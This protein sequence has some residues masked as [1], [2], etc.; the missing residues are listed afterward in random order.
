MHVHFQ[1]SSS[2][3]LKL[4]FLICAVDATL[5]ST[6]RITPFDGLTPTLI[7]NGLEYR[8]SSEFD[9]ERL[10]VQTKAIIGVDAVYVT[11]WSSGHHSA[12]RKETL[13]KWLKEN[14]IKSLW[15]N[16]FNGDHIE[17]RDL[18][19]LYPRSSQKISMK[20]IKRLLGV[21][22]LSLIVKHLFISWHMLQNG[23]ANVL[24]LEDDAKITQNIN[25]IKTRI[26][27]IS[28]ID[29]DIVD[30]PGECS[31]GRDKLVDTH[32]D[33]QIFEATDHM[34]RCSHGYFLRKTGA[35]KLLHHAF[36]HLRGN[37]QFSRAG[38]VT[39]NIYVPFDNLVTST[40]EIKLYYFLNP[41][42][43]TAQLHDS[44]SHMTSSGH[45]FKTLHSCDV[46]KSNPIESKR[47]VFVNGHHNIWFEK[48]AYSLFVD[49]P[50]DVVT[51]Y[52]D[53]VTHTTPNDVMLIGYHGPMSGNMDKFQ[54][55]KLYYNGEFNTNDDKFSGI[56]EE[57]SYYI[58]PTKNEDQKHIQVYY[59]AFAMF[60]AVRT[61]WLWGLN[62][63]QHL[64][65]PRIP[66]ISRKSKFLT[67]T[68]M[69]CVDERETAF[70]TIVEHIS[71]V[72]PKSIIE[73]NGQ[74]Y[75]GLDKNKGMV[76]LKGGYWDTNNK[77][78]LNEFRFTLSMENKISHGYISEKIVN[79]FASHT[80]PIYWG[81]E[82]V[83]NV[84][85]KDAF[86]YYD[87]KNPQPALDQI[88]ELE[89]NDKKYYEMMSKPILAS[90]EALE[91]YF[92]LDNDVGNG[93]LKN[94]I[95]GMLGITYDKHYGYVGTEFSISTP[96]DI[97]IIATGSDVDTSS[98]TKD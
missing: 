17:C 96:A 49:Y 64:T 54:G 55:K 14:N 38:G 83:F 10:S 61:N 22:E 77:A 47:R 7:D 62:Q 4:I 97:G 32:K 67:Y 72:S 95:R 70:N 5:N 52:D 46:Y 66:D 59:G 36:P 88:A 1:L 24:V 75:G 87:T 85:N 48:L 23:F 73:A 41:S 78:D 20:L 2:I 94:R 93:V 37:T 28:D 92:S 26:T 3:I 74:C 30:S 35:S 44:R 31:G 39:A 33:A 60:I 12:G 43:M 18:G 63:Y 40:K 68:Q 8:I 56:E 15:V 98:I 79:A 69:H 27:K 42:P 81:T 19:S 89:M 84:F 76:K 25:D 53:T 21:G 65:A 16:D 91:K 9:Y 13:S 58:G 11:H 57:K 6:Y 82:E 45:H 71:K 86:I 29:W 90:P 50:G 80:V 51:V 34:M